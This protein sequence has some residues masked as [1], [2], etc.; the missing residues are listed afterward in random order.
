MSNQSCPLLVFSLDFALSPKLS[1]I[2]VVLL[3]LLGTPILAL[4]LGCTIRFGRRVRCHY[5]EE[6]VLDMDAAEAGQILGKAPS[7]DAVRLAYLASVVKGE[8]IEEDLQ[9]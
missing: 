7:G 1:E 4:I 5:V 3:V 2:L 8:H 6:D 9:D